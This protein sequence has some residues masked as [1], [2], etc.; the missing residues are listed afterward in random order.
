LY[1][2]VGFV[3]AWLGVIVE[4][5]VLLSS[6]LW[7]YETRDNH[8]VDFGESER[9][10][11]KIIQFCSRMDRATVLNMK[12][13]DF[14]TKKECDSWS[15]IGRWHLKDEWLRSMNSFLHRITLRCFDDLEDWNL[16]S[17]IFTL[18]RLNKSVIYFAMQSVFSSLRTL[19]SELQHDVDIDCTWSKL[20]S[21]SLQ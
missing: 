11:E 19:R 2:R 1:A 21:N 13:S 9:R 8:Q 4:S 18:I 12:P 15:F 20:N 10:L 16:W 14:R 3:H 5:S 7:R 17:T 6:W